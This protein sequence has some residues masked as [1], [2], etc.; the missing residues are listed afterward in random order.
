VSALGRSLPARSRRAARVIDNVIQTD[1]ALNPGSSGGALADTSG[2]VV[3]VSTA[4]AGMGL[5]LAVPVNDA[6]RRVI[7][8]LMSEGRVRRAYIGLAGGPRP[9]PPQARARIQADSCI[10]VVE[11]VEGSPAERAGLRPED[12]ILEVDGA[13]TPGVE[14]LQ[15]LMVAELIDTTVTVR[16]LRQGRELELE[17]VPE[18]L[19]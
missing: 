1:A 17:L 7:G 14:E 8:A 9:L 18:E 3:G 5:G 10:E 13:A 12:L 2:R 4:V 15:R 19:G 6:T 16:L 11:V